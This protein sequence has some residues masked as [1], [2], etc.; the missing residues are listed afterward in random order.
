MLQPP[1]LSSSRERD[2]V[3][4]VVFPGDRLGITGRSL[5]FWYGFVDNRAMER[6]DAQRKPPH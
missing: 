4:A 3:V 6:V 5:S 1:S 2:L